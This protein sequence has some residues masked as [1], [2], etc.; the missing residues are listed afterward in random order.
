MKAFIL[1]KAG[2]AKNL[3]LQEI[4]R[5]RVAPGEVLVKVRAL[6]M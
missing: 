1:P 6:P 4:E 5:P 3:L 2:E